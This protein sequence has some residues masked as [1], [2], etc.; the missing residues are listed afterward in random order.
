MR[1]RNTGIKT[2]WGLI[3]A[4]SLM[5][6]KSLAIYVLG[7]TLT[8]TIP[9]ISL[10]GQMPLA[11]LFTPALDAE[12]VYYGE[13]ISLD[14]I[15]TTPTG[16]PT[17]A[18]ITRVSLE[19]SKQ[20]YL[21]IDAGSYIEPKIPLIQLRNRRVGGRIDL[22]DALP[23]GASEK[24]FKESRELIERLGRG[25]DAVLIG[26]SIPAGT[27]TAMAILRA[28]G[29]EAEDLV[30]SSMKNNP[31]DLKKSVVDKAI[32][33]IRDQGDPF[34]IND[35][36]GDPVHITIAGLV[37]GAM[38]NNSLVILAGGTQM[39]AV[40]ALLKAIDGSRLERVVLATTKWIMKDRGDKIIE[41]IK[42]IAPEISVAYSDLGF[43]DSPHEGLRAY[44][45][46]YVKEGVGAGGTS[47]LAMAKGVDR[48]HLIRSIYREYER[49][50]GKI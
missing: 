22:R 28:F 36:V 17:P 3:D 10:A 39:L 7:S 42:K 24:L 8:S 5:R 26:E 41:F 34:H 35:V 9:N 31:L 4:E 50:M 11:T 15:P 6:K 14:I 29:F 45:E 48:D 20:S 21:F 40:I 19:L 12:Y 33:R 43:E 1:S 49:I 37:S 13:P 44:E 16:I 32:K 47:L 23:K 25:V 18:I 27:T 2:A 38:R 30:S 46:G